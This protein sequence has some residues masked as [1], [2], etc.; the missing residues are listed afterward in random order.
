MS[1]ADFMYYFQKKLLVFP[2]SST[3]RNKTYF[4]GS[5]G[6]V[7]FIK[8]EYENKIYI[9]LSWRVKELKSVVMC[10][11]SSFMICTFKALV[12]KHVDS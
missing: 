4:N 6:V 10:P 11:A 1:V 8:V 12:Y 7:V 5:V 9:V 2:T 3:N